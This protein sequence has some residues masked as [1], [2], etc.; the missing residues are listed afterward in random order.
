MS[1]PTGYSYIARQSPSRAVTVIVY[2]TNPRADATR[3]LIEVSLV[4]LNAS[5]EHP[6]LRG[7]ADAMIRGVRSR[8]SDWRQ[9]DSTVQVAG[10]QAR[11][12]EWTGSS[13]P[14]PDRP[15]NLPALAM[16][17]VMVVGIAAGLGFALHTQ[18]VRPYAD[19]NLVACERAL[20]TFSVSPTAR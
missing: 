2:S 10:V 11:R 7:F 3:G 18:D 1:L 19:S 4:D 17:G 6:T 5:G 16:R 8:H 20:L 13:G 9:A 14:A 15:G 12:F